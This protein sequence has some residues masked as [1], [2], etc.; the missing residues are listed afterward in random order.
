MKRILFL[1]IIVFTALIFS[2]CA[3]N[4]Q[5]ATTD[6]K[7]IS[8]IPVESAIVGTGD[9]SA[10]FTGTATLEAEDEAKV[11]A[12]VYGV[13]NEIFVEEGDYV[14][15]N[16]ALARLDDEQQRFRVKQAHANLNKIKAEFERS[17]ELFQKQLI[18][19]ENFDK[20]KFEVESLKAS[21]NLAE[22]ELKYAT[23]RAPFNGVVSER[24][25]KKGNMITVNQETFKITDF[26]PLNAILY[27][28]ERH[29]NKLQKG[30]TVKFTVDAID[31]KLFSGNVERISPIV[32]P[33]TGTFKV[34]VKIGDPG[35]FLKPGMF[36]RVNIVYDTH[37]NTLLVPK[38]AVMTEDNESSV[39]VIKEDT[40]VVRR[41][42]TLGFSNSSSYEILV[43]LNK[44]DTVVTIGQSSLKD[45]AR[46][47]IVGIPVAAK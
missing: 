6:K 28:P 20:A 12:K 47:V 22:L 10:V 26:E 11:V 40:M 3:E 41:N 8:E 39:Y 34:T 37:K 33:N 14:K 13:V 15:K 21:L 44:G 45:S 24:Y 25:I 38:D 2:S 7:K 43:G 1:T 42:I 4:G 9:I 23:I 16:Q 35:K 32:D 27:V 18:S 5:S 17:K 19:A 46:V 29:L 36:G 31:N 30:Q